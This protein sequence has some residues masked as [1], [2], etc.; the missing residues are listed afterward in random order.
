M[1]EEVVN[2]FAKFYAVNTKIHTSKS[3]ANDSIG[4][5]VPVEYHEGHGH[6][7]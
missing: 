4:K 1:V 7:D 2:I 6:Y 5:D 3:K